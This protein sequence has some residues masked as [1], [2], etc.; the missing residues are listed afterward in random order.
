MLA[1]AEKEKQ[2]AEKIH[3]DDV[4]KMK[5]H[6]N[7]IKELH[8]NLEAVEENVAGKDK[9]NRK[10]LETLNQLRDNCFDIASWC[11][12]TV[13]K[14]FSSAGATSRAS[15]YTSGDTKGALIHGY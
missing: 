7:S 14:I 10:I 6:D 15:S 9:E 11:C 2:E 4:T 5:E 12:D 1:E 13:N 8:I 3:N